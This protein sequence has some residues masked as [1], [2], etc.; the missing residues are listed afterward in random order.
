MIWR[1]EREKHKDRKKK[2]VSKRE[3]KDPVREQQTASSKDCE[4]EE[5]DQ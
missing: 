2:R 1:D 3:V 4:E 5:R